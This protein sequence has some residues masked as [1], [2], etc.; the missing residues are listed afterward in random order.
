[1]KFNMDTVENMVIDIS[2]EL[3]EVV[4]IPSAT[5]DVWDSDHVDHIIVASSD[6][7]IEGMRVKCMIQPVEPLWGT[8]DYDLYLTLHGLANSEVPRIGPIA[9]TIEA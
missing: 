6:L 7:V 9:F 8:G 1:M 5:F 4:T 3:G 2:E